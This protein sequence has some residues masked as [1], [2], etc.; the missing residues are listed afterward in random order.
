MTHLNTLIGNHQGTIFNEILTN[1]P[2]VMAKYVDPQGCIFMDRDGPVFRHILNFL[3]NGALTLPEDFTEWTLLKNE[4]TYYRIPTLL[5]LRTT[6]NSQVEFCLGG[7]HFQL[8]RKILM[9]F[10]LFERLLQGETPISL[11]EDGI[12][13][14]TRDAAMFRKVVGVLQMCDRIAAGDSTQ[15]QTIASMTPETLTRVYEQVFGAGLVG[16]ELRQACE[17]GM[18]ETR[19]YTE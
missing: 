15:P 7:E 5:R 17:A 10:K 19:Y 2:T 11:N 12:M 1:W 8:S 14:L 16:S 13:A 6:L 9:R 3:R 4:I 18:I